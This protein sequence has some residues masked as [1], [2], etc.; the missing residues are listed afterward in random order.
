MTFAVPITESA[1]FVPDGLIED[2]LLPGSRLA[3]GAV[4]AGVELP[5]HDPGMAHVSLD[6]YT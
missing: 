1:A 6:V 3:D 4:V 2:V 5:E